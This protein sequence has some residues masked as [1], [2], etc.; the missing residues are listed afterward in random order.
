MNKV[1]ENL[2]VNNPCTSSDLRSQA[3]TDAVKDYSRPAE[4]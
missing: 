3:A 4:Q 2:M 1:I